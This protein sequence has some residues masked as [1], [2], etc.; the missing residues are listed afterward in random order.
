MQRRNL[1]P[2]EILVLQSLLAETLA[3]QPGKLALSKLGRQQQFAI[4]ATYFVLGDRPHPS[5]EYFVTH[6]LMRLLEQLGQDRERPFVELDGRVRGLIDWQR[7][8]SAR[9]SDDFRPQCFVCREVHRRYDTLPNQLLKYVV[10]QVHA[11]ALAIPRSIRDGACYFPAGGPH[12]APQ[13]TRECLDR[14]ESTLN[15]AR[16]HVGYRAITEPAA[17]TPDHLRAAE[18]AREEAFREV[19]AIYERY[20]AVFS[21]AARVPV[22]LQAGRAGLP[23]PSS[24]DA[25]GRFWVVLGAAIL[26]EHLAEV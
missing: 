4:S 8:I 6:I 17:I 7:T 1:F 24:L 19:V 16:R 2:K 10:E 12:H 22:L 26:R 14:I 23:L 5:T 11:C 13:P 21:S 20:Q 18:Q 25:E 9:Y 3:S 15:L